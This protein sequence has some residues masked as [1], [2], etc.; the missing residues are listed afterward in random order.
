MTFLLKKISQI[1]VIIFVVLF[2]FAIPSMNKSSYGKGYQSGVSDTS[3]EYEIRF[4]EEKESWYSYGYDDG[5]GDGLADAY[6]RIAEFFPLSD[7]DATVWITEN[8]THY[9]K[10]D[11]FQLSG[12]NAHDVSFWYVLS[13]DY[14][15][16]ESCYD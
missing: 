6:S 5:Y 9:H 10:K 14:T 7:V 11:C 3:D 13:H 8:G 2:V 12:H 1:A 16:C 4:D 15:P